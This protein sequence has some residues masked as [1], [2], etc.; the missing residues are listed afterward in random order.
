ML[1]K[2]KIGL[3]LGTYEIPAW[4]LSAIRKALDNDAVEFCLIIKCNPQTMRT[5]FNWHHIFFNTFDKID[6]LIF[7]RIPDAFTSCD[8]RELLPDAPKIEVDLVQNNEFCTI[9][10][11]ALDS[12]KKYNLD[13]IIDIEFGNLQG[14]ILYTAKHGIWTYLHKKTNP[15][16]RT[17]LGFWEVMQRSPTTETHLYVSDHNLQ[18]NKALYRSWHGTYQLSPNRNRNHNAWFSSQILSRVLQNLASLG[19]LDL[20]AQITH[21]NDDHKIP[22]KSSR[23]IPRNLESMALIL[24]HFFSTLLFLCK[25]KLY[26][27]K[28]ILMYTF[29]TDMPRSLQAYKKIVPPRDRFWADPHILHHHGKNY[30]F[31]EEYIYNKN[32]GHLSVI[33]IDERGNYTNPVVILEKETH[34]SYPFVFKWDKK[35]YL[36]PESVET[37]TIELYEAIEFPFKWKHK[38][39]LMEDVGAVDTTL[40]Y[41]DN[42]W[43]LFVGI[44]EDKNLADHNDSAYNTEVFLFYSNDLF[45]KDWQPHPMNPIVSDVRNARPAGSI[46]EKDGKILRPAQ[47]CSIRYGYSV[48]INEIITLSETTYSEK[49]ISSITPS[50]KGIY[51]VHTIANENN[52]TILDAVMMKSKFFQ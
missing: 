22:A 26:E 9:K 39:N 8:L 40:I 37:R 36:I 11:P 1:Q 6:S 2:L 44:A 27:D 3:L 31:I 16:Q 48:N 30:V 21:L 17:P 49:T 46:I 19:N 23:K 42:K 33:E 24:K 51:G 14:D 43:W 28:W 4:I 50:E 41:K 45:T 52:L 15:N 20:L 13:I 7:K 34:L 10:S 12:I 47:D 32:K 25:R 35:F 29:D 5:T 18:S 38:L